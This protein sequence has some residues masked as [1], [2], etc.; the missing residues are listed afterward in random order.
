[1]ITNKENSAIF[2]SSSYSI[3]SRKILQLANCQLSHA[4]F[5]CQL[6]KLLLD[7]SS[8]KEVEFFLKES[9]NHYYCRNQNSPADNFIL[10]II[11]LNDD[12]NSFEKRTNGLESLSEICKAFLTGNV[13]PGTFKLDNNEV[14]CFNNVSEHNIHAGSGIRGILILPVSFNCEN[15]GLL[16]LKSCEENYFRSDTIS[17]YRDL[18]ET[19]GIAFNH[20]LTQ[21]RLR[22]RVKELSCLYNI[23]TAAASQEHTLEQILQEIVALLPAGW[24]YPEILE[25]RIILKNACFQTPGFDDNRTKMSADIIVFKEKYGRVEVLYSKDRPSLDEGPFLF[26][27]RNLLNAIA[28]E[29]GLILERKYSAIEKEKLKEQLRRADRLATIG[30]LAAGVAHELNEPL[31]SILGFAQL[32]QKIDG[33]PQQVN[34]DLQKIINASLNAREIIRKLLVFSRQT[35]SQM[36]KVN[37]NE[38][39]NQCSELIFRRLSQESIKLKTILAADIPLITAD[40]AQLGQVLINLIVNAMQAMPDG[41]ELII[42]T[43]A[44]IGK[45]YIAVS[46]NGIGMSDEIKEKIFVPFFTTKDVN[47]G[48]GLGLAVVHGII[49][50]HGGSISVESEEGKGSKFTIAFPLK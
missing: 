8:C 13:P 32:S 50:T 42:Q 17:W 39:I 10:E 41:G 21:F 19:V 9:P 20:Q 40:A 22:E 47:E 38:V 3:F 44:D 26:E 7:F 14:Y 6:S 4:D 5:I 36:G 31:G 35:Q 24:L 23:A 28:K 12:H 16:I 49:S 33:L 25:G 2:L 1:M 45:A 37:L 27:E 18:A 15:F 34:S 48:T 46:D 43:W 29:I 11:N 30:Q